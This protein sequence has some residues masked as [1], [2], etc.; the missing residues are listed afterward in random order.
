[1][2]DVTLLQYILTAAVLT[3][4]LVYMFYP[5]LLLQLYFRYNFISLTST[6]FNLSVTMIDVT[7]HQ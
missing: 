7:L 1:M 3:G 5:V 2:I 6:R 4:F